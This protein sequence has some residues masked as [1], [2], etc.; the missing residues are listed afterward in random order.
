MAGSEMMTLTNRE[1]VAWLTR[2]GQEGKIHV[3]SF[4]FPDKL[5][6]RVNQK[7]KLVKEEKEFNPDTKSGCPTAE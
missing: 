2:D 1:L 7:Y 4:P 3:S 5:D 6:W